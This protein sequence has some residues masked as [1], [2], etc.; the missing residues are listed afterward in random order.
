[1]KVQDEFFSYELVENGKDI[2]IKDYFN[3]EVGDFLKEFVFFENW[4]VK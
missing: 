1:M 4:Y 3:R 2:I